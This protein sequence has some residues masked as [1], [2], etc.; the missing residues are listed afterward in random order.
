MDNLDAL[1]ASAAARF[2]ERTAVEVQRAGAV[3]SVSYATLGT[4]TLSV[5]SRLAAEGCGKGD[6]VAVLAAN[7]A[8]WCAA[9]LGILRL[10]AVAVPLDTAYTPKQITTLLADSGA[11]VLLADARHA[12][13][14]TAIP[15]LPLESE[16]GGGG[17]ALPASAI[18]PD[19]PAV[20]LYTSGTTSDP[21]GVVLT[22][23][24]FLA[25]REAVFSIV[26]IDERD[27]VLS[28]LPL[29]HALALLANLILPLSMGARVVF[30]ETVNTAELMRALA[31]RDISAFCC[32]PQFFYLV[33]ER[34][35][36]EVQASGAGRR[37]LFRMALAGNGW[38]RRTLRINLGKILFRRI[39]LALGPRMRYLVTGGSRFDPSVGQDMV[40]MGFDLLQAYGLTECSGAA[41]VSRPGDLDVDHVGQ[42]LPGVEVTIAPQ[43]SGQD[44]EI[45]IRGPIV[46]QRYY[47]RPEASAAAVE[48]GWL[49]TGDLGFLDEK[50]RLHVTGRSKEVI[51]LASGKNIYPEEI[52]AHY[53]RSPF[54]KELCVLGR[55]RPG[56]PASERLHAVVVPDLDLMRDRK[57]VNM[58]EQIR[59]EIEGL[60]IELPAHKR[61]LSY[62]LRLQPLPRTTT[63]KLKR[64][65]VER[66]LQAS[67]ESR[68]ALPEASPTA[69]ES[70][71]PDDPLAERALGLVRDAAKPGTRVHAGANLELDLGLDSME[72]VELLVRLEQATGVALPQEVAQRIYTV[73]DLVEALRTAPL[74]NEG[75]ETAGASMAWERILQEGDAKEPVLAALLRRRPV[76]TTALFVLARLL[77]GV[78][79]LTMGFRTRGLDGL[80]HRHPFILS[81]NHQSYLDAF[82]LVSALPY[83]IFR[84]MFFVGA[85]EYFATPL[86][87][88]IARAIHVVPV[89]PDTN[90]VRAMQ[91]GAFG[92]RNGKVLI[93]FPEGERSIDGGLKTFKKGAAILSLHLAVPIVPVAM[94]GVFDVWPRNRAFRWRSLLPGSGTRVLLEVGEP[95]APAGDYAEL[96][97]RLRA[98][99]ERVWLPLRQRRLQA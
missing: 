64:F 66:E 92:L 8:R 31:Q 74:G 81:P 54:V 43:E 37:L 88:R 71:W 78:A 69:D 10:G 21:K 85:S 51:V 86:R 50:N 41:T 83:R 18:G 44:G 30:L 89:D 91:A 23:G 77:R 52:E 87:R 47:R 53:V 19:D 60:S 79:W 99:V 95:L 62:D 58:G 11:K 12:S 57:I 16:G 5:A 75:A 15:V 2:P 72:R 82:L 22:H 76:A 40:R 63:G 48:E 28:V 70:A 6:R 39:H 97:G 34:V 59:F 45:L 29:F 55:S 73:R 35:L 49:R 25:E 1:F 42:P 46:M 84:R 26:R 9:F 68:R 98:A 27:A 36:R 33:R 65:Q 96:T 14:G 24:N 32:V 90:L 93:L 61:I 94:D 56:E 17:V 3:D 80:P 38:L 67:E 13:P 4:M 20:I 7:D